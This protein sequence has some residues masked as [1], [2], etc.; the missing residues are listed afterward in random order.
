[1]KK[2]MYKI[3]CEWAVYGVLDIEAK[4]IKEAIEIAK[5][6]QEICELPEGDYIDG[7]FQL[8]LDEDVIKVLNRKRRN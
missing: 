2:Q 3:P 1:M 8:N 5:K 4:N 7:S 6:E